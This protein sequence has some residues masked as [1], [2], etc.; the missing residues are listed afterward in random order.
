MSK[1]GSPTNNKDNYEGISIDSSS[2]DSILKED[3]DEDQAEFFQRMFS[4]LQKVDL[5]ASNKDDFLKNTDNPD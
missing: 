2:I 1:P 3:I 5:F 4:G